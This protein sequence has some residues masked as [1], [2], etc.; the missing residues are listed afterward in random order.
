MKKEENEEINHGRR[1]FLM[2]LF[3]FVVYSRVMKY[4]QPF[5]VSFPL[6]LLKMSNLGIRGLF[7]V[8]KVM[9]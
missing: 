6:K 4:R 8:I 1:Y 5:Y 7:K 2:S 9:L 3:G